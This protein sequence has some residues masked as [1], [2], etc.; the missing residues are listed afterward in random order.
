MLV[1]AIVLSRLLPRRVPDAKLR[2]RDLLASMGHLL[3]TTPILQRRALYQASLFCAF[4]LF[5][6]VIPLVLA[7][8]DFR[9]SQVGIGLF[10]LAG[11]AGAVAAPVGAPCALI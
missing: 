4:C 3:V 10:A 6:T 9:L 2:Y 11:A 7:G 5:W 8:P 1:L